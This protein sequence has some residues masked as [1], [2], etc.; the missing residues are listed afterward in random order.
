MAAE[1]A[2]QEALWSSPEGFVVVVDDL[3]MVWDTG[4]TRLVFSKA[5]A[6]P[7]E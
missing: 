1:L 3:E 6:P 2:M 4:D 7:D 5:D